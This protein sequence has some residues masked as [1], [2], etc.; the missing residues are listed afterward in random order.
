MCMEL[1]PD[2]QS[3]L[4]EIRADLSKCQT[5]ATELQTTYGKCKDAFNMMT[6]ESELPFLNKAR[7]TIAV[8]LDTTVQR[9]YGNHIW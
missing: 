2:L 6:S 7:E 3:S 8:L 4:D 9:M 1:S 5:E